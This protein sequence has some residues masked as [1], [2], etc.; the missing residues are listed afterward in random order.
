MA[1]FTQQE[2]FNMIMAYSA[3][4]QDAAAA[5]LE[6]RRRHPNAVRFPR[7]ETFRRLVARLLTVH[8]NIMPTP[9]SGLV[10][11]AVQYYPPA[12]ERLVIAQFHEDENISTR[13]VAVRLNVDHHETIYRIAK[14]NGFKCYKFKKVQKL[15]GERDYIARRA[16]CVTF[17]ANLQATPHLLEF[18]LWT[19]ECLFTPNGMFNSK[20]F[21]TWTDEDNPLAYRE[22]RHRYR[23]SLMVW[24]GILNGNIVS[25]PRPFLKY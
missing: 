18:I 3:A 11:R 13:I 7:V 5:V 22:C 10:D 16:F 24:A 14:D 1:Y 8:G 12:L 15:M 21:V 17:Q 20:N 25:L 6:Y 19:D 23:W 4:D 2:Y 9:A